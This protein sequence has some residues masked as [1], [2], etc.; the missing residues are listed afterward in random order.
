MR[1]SEAIK[2][3]LLI[4]EERGDIECN[5]KGI[6]HLINRKVYYPP[7]PSPSPS[8]SFVLSEPSYYYP[9]SPITSDSEIYCPPSPRFSNIQSE[10]N[11]KV[12]LKCCYC[13]SKFIEDVRGNCSA[14]GARNV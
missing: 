1:I 3:L 5:I 11:T 12:L 8:P 7:S 9:P 10:E 14:C 13:G 4:R 6:E 2:A